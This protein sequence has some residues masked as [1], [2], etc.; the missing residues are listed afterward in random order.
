MMYAELGVYATMLIG[1]N[2]LL[3]LYESLVLLAIV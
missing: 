3:Q 2:V 1:A